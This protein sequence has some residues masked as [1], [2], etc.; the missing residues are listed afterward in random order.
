MTENHRFE[1]YSIIMRPSKAVI[2]CPAH[3]DRGDFIRG[4][5][6]RGISK[7]L[8]TDYFTNRT[9]FICQKGV[10]SHI[11]NIKAISLSLNLEKNN[12]VLFLS[13]QK[14]FS[15]NRTL[16]I[17][18]TPISQT[19]STKSPGVIVDH[20]LPVKDHVGSYQ[21]KKNLQRIQGFC[22]V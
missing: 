12:F 11:L 4:F 2:I 10:K 14:Q 13:M 21:F 5:C 19:I 1:T 7:Q 15:R 9:K 20:D 3:H 16:L 8:F 17:N 18:D 6:L 22:L